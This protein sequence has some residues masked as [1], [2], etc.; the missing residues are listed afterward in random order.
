MAKKRE[1]KLTG[2]SLAFCKLLE[3]LGY[4]TVIVKGEKPNYK[5]CDKKKRVLDS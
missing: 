2:L 1:P 4:K 3:S 5:K